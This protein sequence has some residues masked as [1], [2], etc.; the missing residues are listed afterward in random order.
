MDERLPGLEA[1]G[2]GELLLL[3]D[4]VPVW[5]DGNIW[6]IDSADGCTTL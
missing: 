5:G 3:G 6:E 4:R 1:R 2:S